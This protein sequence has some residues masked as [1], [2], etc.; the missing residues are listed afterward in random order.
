MN[1][2]HH[3]FGVVECFWV[4]VP[5]LVT[6][7]IFCTIFLFLLAKGQCGPH[8]HFSSGELFCSLGKTIAWGI[9]ATWGGTSIF[10][11]FTL[12]AGI[13]GI[14]QSALALNRF[15]EPGTVLGQRV[16]SLT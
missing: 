2:E 3:R 8:V 16:S 12:G 10:S 1:Q 13:R 9:A 5:L 14:C 7:P 6:I 11:T 15:M 4:V